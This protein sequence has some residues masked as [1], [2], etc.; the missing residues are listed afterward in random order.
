LAWLIDLTDER[1]KS[2]VNADIIGY[3]QRANP[4]AHSDLGQK[5]IDLHREL[6]GASVY[7]PDFK[8]CAYVVLHNAAN[9]IF[10]FAAD[11]RDLS[12]R[13]PAAFHDEA[14]ASGHGRTS[15]IGGE[16][17]DVAAFPPGGQT[18]LAEARLSHYCLTAQRHAATLVLEA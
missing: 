15:R 5:L 1:F 18:A 13:L 16:W 7:C 3:I 9:V 10:A 11:M 2:P 8:V 6:Q 12:F 17:L 4:F 14:L